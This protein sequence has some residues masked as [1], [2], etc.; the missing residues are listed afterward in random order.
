MTDA[1]IL[2]VPPDGHGFTSKMLDG[3][4]NALTSGRDLGGQYAVVAIVTPSTTSQRRTA[5]GFKRTVGLEVIRLEPLHDD[6]SIEQVRHMLAKAYERR[7]G[8]RQLS[9][10]YAGAAE[11]EQRRELFTALDEWCAEQ[12][13]AKTPDELGE[14]WREYI[15][16]SDGNRPI[17]MVQAPTAYLREFALYIGAIIDEKV[18]S[19]PALPNPEDSPKALRPFTPVPEASFL[20]PGEPTTDGSDT[21]L[22]EE[23]ELSEEDDDGKDDGALSEEPPADAVD[24]SAAPTAGLRAVK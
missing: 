16:P 15:G 9:L 17:A 12:E 22:G 13:P 8:G 11:I 3:I 21:S 20:A 10:E 23:T 7:T 2:S 14:D 24:E 4:Y 19:Q 1:R 18:A 5:K 6:D